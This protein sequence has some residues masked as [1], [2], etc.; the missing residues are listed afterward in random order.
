MSNP[1]PDQAQFAAQLHLQF[2]LFARWIELDWRNA[3]IIAD[4]LDAAAIAR[5]LEQQREA[6]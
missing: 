4:N 5:F 6:A 2:L 3:E 1:T